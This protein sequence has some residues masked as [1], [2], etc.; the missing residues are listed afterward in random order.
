ME[1]NNLIR[2]L[3]QLNLSNY[4]IEAINKIMK[5]FDRFGVV[6]IT[7]HAGKTIIRARSNESNETFKSVSDLSYRQA[8]CNTKFR[9]ASTPNTTMFYGCVVPGNIGKEEFDTSRATAITEVSK[10]FRQESEN[11]EEKIT[12][13]RWIVSKEISLIAIVYHKDFINSSLHTNELYSAYQSFLQN[14]PKDIIN[15]NKVTEYFASEFAKKE[16]H[17]D[18]DYLISALFTELITKEGYAGV[19]YPSVRSEGKGFNVAI[20]PDFVENNMIP[21]VVGECMLYKKAK[22]YLLDDETITE[23]TKGQ[24]DFTLNPILDTQLHKGREICHKILNGKIKQ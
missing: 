5:E 9:R 13:S 12:F 10:L 21:V 24:T 1:A 16:T 3:R 22:Q 18:Y 7:L 19:Y 2:K 11:G 20:H 14:N 23:I 6:V 8:D 4:P 15:S 17:H